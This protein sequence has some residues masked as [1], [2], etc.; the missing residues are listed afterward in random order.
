[1]AAIAATALVL[2]P[3]AIAGEEQVEVQTETTETTVTTTE[4]VEF[5]QLDADADGFVVQAEIPTDIEL[6]Q[7]WVDLDADCDMKLSQSEVDGWEAVGE[8]EACESS[9][10]VKAGAHPARAAPSGG[11]NPIRRAARPL[12]ALR[13]AWSWAG[14]RKS[15][16]VG[17]SRI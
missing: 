14:L 4:T 15:P 5:T 3:F 2:S 16:V 7:V 9:A 6:A 17:R 10:I 12:S 13:G 1:S 8:E 11:W